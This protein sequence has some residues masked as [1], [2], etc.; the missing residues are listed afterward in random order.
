MKVDGL[1]QLDKALNDLPLKARGPIIRGALNKA[2]NPMLNAARTLSEVDSPKKKI[3]KKASNPRRKNNFTA[4]VL[5]GFTK[6]AWY[7]RL[8][9]TGTS[10]HK[11]RAKKAS[12]LTDQVMFF[13]REVDHP[14]ITARPFLRPAYDAEHNNF[15]RI[16]KEEMKRRITERAAK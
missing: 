8:I 15:I 11:I 9:E 6:D 3:I 5:I 13:G 7:L 10:A 4:E 12:I 1:R 14:G 2:A 16:F